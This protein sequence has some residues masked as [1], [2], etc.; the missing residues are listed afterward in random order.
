MASTSIVGIHSANSF[1]VQALWTIFSATCVLVESGEVI[2]VP[3]T[4]IVIHE[5]SPTCT[6]HLHTSKPDH[7]LDSQD[8]RT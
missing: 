6:N 5:R 7:L 1:G 4:A 8:G 2:A 3:R